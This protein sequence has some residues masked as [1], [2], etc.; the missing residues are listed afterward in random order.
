MASSSYG[1]SFPIGVGEVPTEP[2]VDAEL[3]DVSTPDAADGEA[4]PA[5]GGSDS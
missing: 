1:G 5:D 2:A 3:G 4:A